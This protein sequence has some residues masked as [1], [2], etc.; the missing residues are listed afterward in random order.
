[1]FG[2]LPANINDDTQQ[3]SSL[4]QL[5]TLSGIPAVL[6]MSFQQPPAKQHNV[7]GFDSMESMDSDLNSG[8]T[9]PMNYMRKTVT[10][11]GVQRISGPIR[12]GRSVTSE[13]DDGGLGNFLRLSGV[14]Y[15]ESTTKALE[16]ETFS[17]LAAL[18][19]S[20]D[21]TPEPWAPLSARDS[22]QN[23]NSTSS[24]SGLHQAQSIENQFDNNRFEA[25]HRQQ[26]G[27]Y[28]G[29]D[30]PYAVRVL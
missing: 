24:S 7:T 30:Q 23:F 27:Y 9:T 13:H 11:N 15:Y 10:P 29:I 21:L 14:D 25:S 18:R 26:N 3:P 12:S 22:L 20:R 4:P 2:D 28:D 5:K 17:D 6:D 8:K 19:E 16:D 1:M